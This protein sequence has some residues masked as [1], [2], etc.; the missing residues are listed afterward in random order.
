VP[1]GR[2]E[3]DVNY[4]DTIDHVKSKYQDITGIPIDQQRL[5]Y[6]GKQLEDGR[7]VSDYNIT[8]GST[9]HVVLRLRGLNPQFLP[10]L[11]DRAPSETVFPE[12]EKAFATIDKWKELA[13]KGGFEADTHIVDPESHYQVLDSLQH[14]VI[15][16]SELYHQHGVYK[17]THGPHSTQPL[18]TARLLDVPDWFLN[19]VSELRYSNEAVNPIITDLCESYLIVLSLQQRLDRLISHGFSSSFFSILLEHDDESVAE[20]LKIPRAIMVD[21]ASA[22]EV[23]ITIAHPLVVITAAELETI[24]DCMVSALQKISDILD[25]PHLMTL[26]LNAKNLADVHRLFKSVAYILDLGLVCYAAS[27]AAR[28]DMEYFT[29]HEGSWSYYDKEGLSFDCTLRPLACLNGFLDARSVWVFRI[30]VGLEPSPAL[31][32][33]GKSVSIL[34]TI[35]ALS[36][37]WGPVWAEAIDRGND[38]DGSLLIKKYHVSKGCIRRVR[39]ATGS[40]VP[41]VV[42]CHWYSWSEEYRRRFSSLFQRSDNNLYMS[43]DDKLLI[44]A[45]VSVKAGCTYSLQEYEMNY[46]HMIRPLGAKPSSWRLDGI[47]ANVQMTAPKVI[48]FQIEGQVKKVPETTIKQSILQ[49]WSFNPQAAN[50]GVLN[51]YYGVEI[52]HCTGNARRVPLKHILLMPPVREVLERQIPKWSTT[53]WGI[54]FEKALQIESN[55]AV[56]QFWNHYKAERALVGQLVC[57]V[58]DI[59]DGT[60]RTDLGLHAALLYQNRELG[61][62]L[63]YDKNEWAGL[64]KDS[65]LTA[66]Y[67]IINEVCLECRR[68]DHTTSICGDES[69]YTV[70][71][72]EIGLKRGSELGGRLKVEPHSLTF[73]NIDES[74][75][76]GG[77]HYLTPESTLRRTFSLQYRLA[78]GKELLHQDPERLNLQ[79]KKVVFRAPVKSF[80]GM[81]YKRDRTLL[82]ALRNN[83]A[84]DPIDIDAEVE[85][86]EGLSQLEI[87]AIIKTQRDSCGTQGGPGD[88]NAVC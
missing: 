49:K 63:D 21:L 45:A 42:K 83:F 84:T 37:I 62:D 16:S 17:P 69:R 1:G 51:N 73:K 40:G 88:R 33:P 57:C 30:G 14:E 15:T 48:T 67:A 54:A 81:D 59:L 41:G 28:F 71:Q 35:D 9:L 23:V 4:G 72:T 38:G 5:I 3:I 46:G 43:L 60:G 6:D 85:D 79:S 47:A 26:L 68:P 18:D 32:R 36:D 44:G 76:I 29:K 24:V 86:P 70:L 56:F 64:L 2:Y 66:A 11:G 53:Q 13:R 22:L 50:P 34:T 75:A 82:S 12:P 31:V 74:Q 78:T 65:Y 27:H 87:E 77:A 20:I 39:E 19:V 58:L 25:F 55:E 80:G 10:A 8:H 61:V 7:T 52:S